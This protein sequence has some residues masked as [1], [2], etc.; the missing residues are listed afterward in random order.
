MKASIQLICALILCTMMACEKE[1]VTNQPL[2]TNAETRSFTPIEID[3]T[4]TDESVVSIEVDSFTLNVLS[5]T[6]FTVT[7]WQGN[8]SPQSHTATFFTAYHPNSELTITPRGGSPYNGKST[9]SVSC[10]GNSLSAN[11][12]A[13]N[14]TISTPSILGQDEDGL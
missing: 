10:T 13:G 8:D 14:I 7:S 9:L 5:A 6:T 1:V 4:L 2:K 3:I 12:Q 11:I